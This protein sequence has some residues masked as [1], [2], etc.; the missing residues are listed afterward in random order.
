MIFENSLVNNELFIMKI[1]LNIIMRIWKLNL[2][3]NSYILN[4]IWTIY[5]VCITLNVFLPKSF[6]FAANI[7][8]PEFFISEISKLDHLKDRLDFMRFKK[9][10]QW[11]L[12]EIGIHYLNLKLF[13]FLNSNGDII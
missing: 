8:H 13:S 4:V 2:F 11:H 3:K 9:K 7:D 10:V 1:V 5:I 6:C 12:F